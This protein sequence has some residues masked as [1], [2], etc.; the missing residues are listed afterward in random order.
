MRIVHGIGGS[1]VVVMHAFCGSLVSCASAAVRIST[2]LHQILVESGGLEAGTLGQPD[3]HQRSTPFPTSM[4]TEELMKSI[5]LAMADGRTIADDVRIAD[6]FLA[7][8]LGLLRHRAL[9]PHE[10]LLLIP[11]GNVHTIG[12][13][14]PID[15]VFLDRRM[16]VIRVAARLAP[17]RVCLAPRRTANV[18]Q[19]AAGR[20]AATELLVGMYVL[21]RDATDLGAALHTAAGTSALPETSRTASPVQFSLRLPPQRCARVDSTLGRTTQRLP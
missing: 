6:S 5:S 2:R 21:V 20:V 1:V 13:R 18:L 4:L 7:R 16:R 19:L 12:L 11:G 15:V 17:H 9:S 10:G 3:A 14:F 8:N